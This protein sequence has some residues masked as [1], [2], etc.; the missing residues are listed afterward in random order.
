MNGHEDEKNPIAEEFLLKVG[1][2]AIS[3]ASFD[4]ISGFK[5]DLSTAGLISSLLS[6][7]KGTAKA[8]YIEKFKHDFSK[9]ESVEALKDDMTKINQKLDT[10]LTA[11]LKVAGM[12]FVKANK[13]LG[14]DDE[15]E[16]LSAYR[17]A[18]DSA[19]EAIARI[20]KIDQLV[21]AYKIKLI[22]EY[23]RILISCKAIAD[24]KERL[25]KL[26]NF[27]ITSAEFLGE[28][29]ANPTIASAMESQM[30]P[31][32][33]LFAVKKDERE[34]LLQEL[35]YLDNLLLNLSMKYQ[36]DL[37]LVQPKLTTSTKKMAINH[38]DLM[39]SLKK[40]LRGHTSEIMSVCTLADNDQIV[41]SCSL[42]KTIRIWN[43]DT[44]TCLRTLSGHTAGVLSLCSTKEKII[45]GSLDHSIRIWDFNSGLCDR[46]LVGH[47]DS[48][49]SVCT[50]D[51]FIISGSSDKTIRIWEMNTGLCIRRL[52]GHTGTDLCVRV[53]GDKIISG[54]TD[55]TIRIWE[56]N[57][58]LCVGILTG[59]TS[60][61][62][63]LCC[64][65]DKIIS[66]SDDKDGTI[67]IWDTNTGLCEQIIR[68]N[69]SG[70]N[71]LCVFRDTFISG[72]SDKKIRIWD[73]SGKC[74]RTLSGHLN[75]IK[76]M[77]TVQEKIITGSPDQNIR[78]FSQKN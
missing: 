60:A 65:G 30:D 39:N 2:D 38:L 9:Q 71:A 12:K 41:I 45:S 51:K 29:H 13:L 64:S 75:A 7:F 20:S 68:G 57:T 15:N 77:C 74:I 5:F 66:G 19:I 4:G 10:L 34:F 18:E 28:L 54:S 11:D 14:L 69:S 40:P 36:V 16:A 63:S 56:L 53:Y 27:C 61:I 55:N 62:T 78:I 24:E 67:R 48:V 1:K 35:C 42:D 22:S 25:K 21:M 70:I 17:S 73:S 3:S 43:L 72:S 58:G 32:L 76:C 52:A 59:H 26:K 47:T 46:V 31:P 6:A 50:C 33:L 37:E 23:M 44:E 8:A 49:T